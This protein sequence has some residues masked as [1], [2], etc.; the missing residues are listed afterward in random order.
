LLERNDRLRSAALRAIVADPGR[1]ALR[2]FERVG[3]TLGPNPGSEILYAYRDR[4]SAE[5]LIAIHAAQAF[6][7]WGVAAAGLV[8]AWPADPR[9]R[10]A[11]IYV[12]LYIGLV[13]AAVALPRYRLPILPFACL[14]FAHAL[15]SWKGASPRRRL[16][17]GIVVLALAANALYVGT[18]ERAKLS[19]RV[20]V[21]K[22]E[23]PPSP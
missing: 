1:F 6:L 10:L 14:L 23:T 7:L 9:L 19:E 2:A 5:G 17:A 4:L 18:R 20:E 22:S 15:V 3:Q 8:L 16:F 11:A 21:W 12:A 13:A